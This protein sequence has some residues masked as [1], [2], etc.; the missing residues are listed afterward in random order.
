MES[1][2]LNHIK[3]NLKLFNNQK[4]IYIFY[5]K[6]NIKKYKILRKLGVN[7]IKVGLKNNRMD[8]DKILKKIKERQINHLLV[9]GGKMLT[10]YFVNNNFFNE[11]YLF[12]SSL[13]L[14]KLGQNNILATIN[15]LDKQFK[16]K[17]K[18]NTYLSNDVLIHYK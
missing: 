15:K 7:L 13:N 8:I 4:K 3:V 1:L 18:I 6:D 5:N 9:E 2:E 11:F 14:K 16:N 10:D 12:K 17:K